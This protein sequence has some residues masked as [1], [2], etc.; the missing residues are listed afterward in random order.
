MNEETERS[1]SAETE[2]EQKSKTSKVRKVRATK[3]II[4]NIMPNELPD[5]WRKQEQ[6]Q[7]TRLRFDREE[8]VS[9]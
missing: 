7:K 1:D 3:R 8:S 6:E 2:K 9:E 4:N 5:G